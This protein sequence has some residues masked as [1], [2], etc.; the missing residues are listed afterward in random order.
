MQETTTKAIQSSGAVSAKSSDGF[1]LVNSSFKPVFVNPIAA[2]ILAFPEKPEKRSGEGSLASKIRSLFFSGKSPV[3]P[4]PATAFQSGRRVYECRAYSVDA[5]AKGDSVCMAMLL[6]RRLRAS[7]GLCQVSEKFNLTTR[8]REVLQHLS[9]GR[10]TKEI[11]AGME[12]SP[13]TVKA[14]VRMI[15]VKMGVSTRSGIVGKAVGT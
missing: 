5:L 6:Q 7:T 3:V 10:T 9:E 13:N 15:M 12:I 2:E 14:F 1:I 4:E 8:E 11:A